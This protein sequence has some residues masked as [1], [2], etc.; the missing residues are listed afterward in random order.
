MK[1]Q[2]KTF[3]SVL[4][5]GIRLNFSSDNR[6]FSPRLNDLRN[7]YINDCKQDFRFEL[8]FLGLK[9]LKFLNNIGF[10][11]PLCTTD[12]KKT[13]PTTVFGLGYV[14]KKIL[15]HSS[16]CPGITW[17]NYRNSCPPL[18]R[19]FDIRLM[20]SK[21]RNFLPL[22]FHPPRQNRLAKKPSWAALHDLNK[23]WAKPAKCGDFLLTSQLIPA[24][25][26]G[27]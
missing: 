24:P 1:K 20:D 11:G 5:H 3:K 16:K 13:N 14:F 27:S 4:R 2:N 22:L 6:A 12:V 7:G 19:L 9:F 15:G 26:G 18:C 10:I 23:N 25:P 21:F 8:A 17:E